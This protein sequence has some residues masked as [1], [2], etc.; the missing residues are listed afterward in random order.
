MKS[1]PLTMCIVPVRKIRP[2]FRT[3]NERRPEGTPDLALLQSWQVNV[4]W[5]A[6][7]QKQLLE[8]LVIDVIIITLADEDGKI[9]MPIYQRRMIQDL[10]RSLS[11]MVGGCLQNGH[12][13]AAVGLENNST[14]PVKRMAP[15]AIIHFD[16][17]HGEP[18]STTT[19]C[20]CWSPP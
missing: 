12:P 20:C 5:H 18:P 9:I 14:D 11:S 16:L 3:G 4:S 17:R 15:Y 8:F 7:F 19:N 1:V 13:K 10:A 2:I 6:P